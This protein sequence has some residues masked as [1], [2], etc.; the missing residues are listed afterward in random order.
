MSDVSAALEPL[1][2]AGTRDGRLD[3]VRVVAPV[4][5][6][7]RVPEGHHQHRLL[8]RDDVRREATQRRR[9]V[10][11]VGAHAAARVVGEHR[12]QRRLLHAHAV[13]R[14]GLHVAR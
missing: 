10:G 1:A 5:E 13:G 7:R 12:G 14:A 4:V 8:A 6:Q 9:H 11:Q 3:L 2:L